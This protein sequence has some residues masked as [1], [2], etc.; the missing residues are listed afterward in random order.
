MSAFENSKWIWYRDGEA[1]D[2]YADF[3]SKFNYDGNGSVTCRISCDGDYTLYINGCFAA[4]NQYGDY[5]H[6]K[7]YDEIDITEVVRNGENTFSATVWHHG[8]STSRYVYGRAGV[9]FEITAGEREILSSGSHTLARKNPAYHSGRCQFISY[10]LGFGFAYD[11]TKDDGRLF[12]G[13]GFDNAFSADKKCRLF[14]RPN[15][16]LCLESK[17]APIK[18]SAGSDGK[19]YLIDLGC[20]S[21]G[22]LHLDFT[23]ETEQDIEIAWGEDLQNGH[24]RRT[25][26]AREFSI[27]YRARIGENK[28]TNHMLRFGVRYFEVYAEAPIELRY[29]GLI[30]QYYPVK[31]AVAI[32]EDEDERKIYELCLRTLRLCMMEH[33]V[34]C[35][36]REQAFYAYDS[37]NQMLSG[38]YAFEGGNAEYAK[39][40]LKLINADPGINGLLSICYPSAGKRAIPS[41]SL[42]FFTAVLEYT[43]H[44]GDIE[45]A[46]EII[47]KLS[48]IIDTFLQNSENG[49]I[50]KF[51]GEQYWNFYDWTEALEGN[52]GKA[53][54]KIPD[55]VINLL[56]LKA[57]ICF[58]KITQAAGLRFEHEDLLKSMPEAVKSAFFNTETGFYRLHKDDEVYTALANS[59]AVILGIS[60]GTEAEKI[61]SAIAC[62]EITESTLSLKCFDYDALLSC[63]AERYRDTVLSDIKKN[64]MHMLDA[65]ATSAWETI[66][67]AADF[68]NA[69]S[70]CHGWSAIPIYY[71]HILGIIK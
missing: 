8:E 7:I 2:E 50:C 11:A 65:G 40:N 52:L 31:A 6:Y 24:V 69:G 9:I 27:D 29:A 36:W 47:P 56:F 62:G 15:K 17:P 45:F 12:T 22:I 1:N 68:D 46:R 67:G 21:V 28:Y 54:P 5:E 10:Q 25:I 19:Y 3:F 51:S 14:P 60:K 34:D 55:S 58:K 43:E 38:Y 49:L 20:E 66:K 33:Y 44:T 48:R 63:D 23:S 39:S 13:E 53:D 71:Y 42:Q 18:T 32:P 57:L 70:L 16:K 35:P 26:G 61:C 30:P 64:Y 41:F 59:L 37:R 4:S